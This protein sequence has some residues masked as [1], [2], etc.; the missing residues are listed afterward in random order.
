MDFSIHTQNIFNIS[1]IK[2]STKIPCRVLFT[3]F[4]TKNF[5][6]YNIYGLSSIF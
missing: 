4:F 1:H 6:F 3:L 5:C 2:P